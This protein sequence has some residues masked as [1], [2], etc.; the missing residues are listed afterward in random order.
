MPTTT[1]VVLRLTLLA[2]GAMGL[3]GCDNN[4]AQR[5]PPPCPTTVI[6]RDT[7]DLARFRGAG[8]DLTDMVLDGRITGL[9]GACTRTDDKTVTTTL[10]VALELTRGPANPARTAEVAY[11]V[12]VSLGD[13]ILDKQVIRLRAE[14]PSNTDRLRLSGDQLELHLPVTPTR[15]AADYKIQVG[16]QLTPEELAGNRQRQVR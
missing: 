8:R 12:A 2:T 9:G 1:C 10:T 7:A 3:A 4:S 16:F 6:N 5:F 15:T 13:D 14:F 11:F